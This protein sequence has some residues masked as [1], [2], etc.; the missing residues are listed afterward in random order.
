MRV[1]QFSAIEQNSI[2]RSAID[3]GNIIQMHPEV[4]QEAERISERPSEMPSPQPSPQA[5]LPSQQTELPSPQ[6]ELPSP[7]PE[8]LSP[9]AESQ[10]HAAITSQNAELQPQDEII[11]DPE[12]AQRGPAS[13]EVNG[14]IVQTPALPKS[15]ASEEVEAEIDESPVLPKSPVAEETASNQSPVVPKSPVP[16]ELSPDKVLVSESDVFD[17]EPVEVQKGES[18]FDLESSDSRFAS[19]DSFQSDRPPYD[20]EDEMADDERSDS[21][22]PRAETT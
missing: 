1:A 7:Q 16:E 21:E 2:L 22:S 18:R 12:L 4:A 15:L 17:S 3:V 8:L 13:Q 14:E 20:P 6:P 19:T 9:Q 5:V 10:P 11:S